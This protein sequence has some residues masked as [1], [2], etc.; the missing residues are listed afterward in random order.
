MSVSTL[1]FFR[2]LA[3]DNYSER[4]SAADSLGTLLD[5]QLAT[6]AKAE[7]EAGEEEGE[8]EEAE[9]DGDDDD[10]ADFKDAVAAQDV[11]TEADWL[12]AP[13]PE[14]VKA[15]QATIDRLPRE[16]SYAVT[17][18]IRGLASSRASARLGFATA[19][20]PLLAKCS[21]LPKS[22]LT[23]TAFLQLV[24]HHT[25]VP[26]RSSGQEERDGLIAKLFAIHAL[27]LGPALSD[28]FDPSPHPALKLATRI[29]LAAAASKSWLADAAAAVLVQLYRVARAQPTPEA[30]RWLRNKLF[31]L[32]SHPSSHKVALTSDR[33]AVLIA[34]Q[35]TLP[36][37]NSHR[38]EADE[39]DWD[40]RVCPPL[41]LPHVLAEENVP[42]LGRLLLDQPLEE[43]TLS[44]QAAHKRSSTWSADLPMSLRLI[45]ELYC[46]PSPPAHLAAFESVWFAVVDEQLL[47]DSASAERKLWGLKMFQL[48]LLSL[49]RATGRPGATTQVAALFSPNL[50]RELVYHTRKSDRLLHAAAKQSM[51]VVRHVAQSSPTW[52]RVMLE[53]VLQGE[54]S[55]QG[56]VGSLLSPTLLPILA[57]APPEL[58]AYLDTVKKTLESALHSPTTEAQ[59]EEDGLPPRA[60][61]A[62]DELVRVLRSANKKE[63]STTKEV[64]GLLCQYSTVSP[65]FG[66]SNKDS[67]DSANPAAQV[68][69]QALAPIALGRLLSALNDL[70][71]DTEENWMAWAWDYVCNM[72]QMAFPTATQEA[73]AKGKKRRSS[74]APAQ[75]TYH[76]LLAPRVGQALT[77]TVLLEP[78]EPTEEEALDPCDALRDARSLLSSLNLRDNTLLLSLRNLVVACALYTLKEP[79]GGTPALV[80]ATEVLRAG[81][82]EEK[83][84]SLVVQ[85][86]LTCTAQPSAFLRA[87]AER[88]FSVY[89][90]TLGADDMEAVV[91]YVLPPP[92]GD[93]SDEHSD[94]MSDVEQDDNEDAI[95]SASDADGSDSD[96]SSDSGSNSD[97]LS[98]EGEEDEQGEDEVD[99]EL[100][101][102]LQEAL[103]DAADATDGHDGDGSETDSVVA[104]DEQMLALDD[105]LAAIFRLR[106]RRTEGSSKSRREQ[107][108]AEAAIHNRILDMLDVYVRHTI[109]SAHSGASAAHVGPS[110]GSQASNIVYL[111]NPLLA[112]VAE[113]EGDQKALSN[114][115][116]TDPSNPPKSKAKSKAL[117]VRAEASMTKLTKADALIG[118]IVSAKEP[119]WLPLGSE[120]REFASNVAVD[121]LDTLSSNNTLP[122]MAQ[123]EKVLLF[124]I[125][126]LLHSAS[127]EAGRP[128]EPDACWEAVVGKFAAAVG[129][130]VGTSSVRKPAVRTKFLSDALNRFAHLGWAVREAALP[131]LT[132]KEGDKK[133]SPIQALHLLQVVAGQ[134]VT[135]ALKG[136]GEPQDRV[137]VYLTHVFGAGI[138]LAQ[139]ELSEA[140]SSSSGNNAA[141]IKEEI[142]FLMALQRMR[143][144]L[145]SSAPA[146]KDEP[147]QLQAWYG[148]LTAP[149]GP[150]AQTKSVHSLARQ[151][152]SLMG[153]HVE[154]NAP[155][156]GTGKKDAAAA[157]R[158]HTRPPSQGTKRAAANAL[159][160]EQEQEQAKEH[161]DESKDDGDSTMFPD[162]DTT[163]ASFVSAPEAADTSKTSGVASRASTKRSKKSKKQKTA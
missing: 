146:G 162:A 163:G 127:A 22:R 160:P 125:R 21:T 13:S 50:M 123:A 109:K 26:A 32:R 128:G 108:A 117:Q 92:E 161:E 150:Y 155:S 116:K 70:L 16:V 126:S 81:Q 40:Q 52:A 10:D 82:G 31:P 33:L 96:S 94:A 79:R 9:E 41:K 11:P 63:I 68:W 88:T 118:R 30:E 95:D 86:V 12:Q 99:P 66:A 55:D 106:Q 136:T 138:R 76:W 51:D 84:T 39:E 147:A 98:E 121:L 131:A 80:Q 87:V 119:A 45:I 64:L 29:A 28:R 122:A 133:T 114:K 23:P 142:K 71:P 19:L 132:V 54:H 91:R 38:T 46:S 14:T 73:Q 115:T 97:S 93:D 27:A 48:M 3:S 35:Y 53:A 2:T 42:L 148:S 103:G 69:L 83:P 78:E 156:A 157:A 110:A 144:R 65:A 159:E 153:I 20:T 43:N 145:N 58:N 149:E 111:L 152:L 100:V 102:K 8:R 17:R 7:D 57:Q 90:P 140:G 130:A 154:G 135:G 85:A 151:L 134:A 129:A 15:A 24:R 67:V 158:A 113:G 25:A 101:K 124:L 89:A 143:R 49:T 6:V 5:A 62:L 34:L 74:A 60:N 18:L 120:S 47:S 1:P 112:I 77:G 107:D 44:S 61:W 75:P 72:A 56:T 104:D 59:D 4:V 137:H 37:H 139:E 105:K 141:R 36:A